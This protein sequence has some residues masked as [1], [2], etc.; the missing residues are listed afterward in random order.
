M[1]KK[2]ELAQIVGDK[3]V[4]YDPAILDAYSKDSSF[5]KPMKPRMVV[6]VKNVD[7]VQKI[8]KWANKTNTPLIPISSGPPHH[9]GD[10]VASVPESVII[11]LSGMKKIININ[12]Q[13]RICIIEPGVT[14]GELQKALAKEGLTTSTS[15]APRATK[16]VIAN[17]MD[18]EPGT[19]AMSQWEYFDPLKCMEVVWGDGNKMFTGE[20]A[21]GPPELEKQWKSEK[22]QVI[23]NGPFST[24]FLRMLTMSQGTMGIVTWASLKCEILPT[25]HKM[26]F[27]PATKQE[28]L[29]EFVKRVIRLRFSDELMVMNSSYLAGII[30]ETEEEVKRFKS[31]LP[32]WVALVGI[33]GRNLLPEE[34]VESQELD[35]ADIAQHCGLKML[36]ALPGI[37]G[38]KLLDKIIKPSKEKYWKETLKGSYQDIFF[39]TTLEKSTG[40]INAVNKTA[41]LEGYPVSDIGVYIQPKHR[42]SAYHM[43]FN[44][45]YDPENNKET[46]VVKNLYTKASEE[47]CSMG[48]YFSRPYG[49]WSKLQLNRDAQSAM[50]LKDLKGIFDPNNVMNPGK[51]TV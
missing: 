32:P 34:R 10:T 43:E 44:F 25:I 45:P 12:T 51:L 8:V 20:A 17:V 47:L 7:E 46:G 14:Y 22:W 35:I 6:K 18:A 38:E 50:V 13:Q 19:N 40:Y 28:D 15:V 31:E 5:S 26:F 2:T 9:R 42:G 16:S 11:D 33:L 1:N 37:N 29:N 41:D 27:V 24:D 36:P 4:I 23:G 21:Q 3:N 30:G 39:L 49:I 48:A